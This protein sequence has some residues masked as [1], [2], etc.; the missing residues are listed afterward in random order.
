MTA[1][2]RKS[3]TRFGHWLVGAGV[4]A[5]LAFAWSG[6]VGFE[7]DGTLGPMQRHLYLATA[8]TLVIFFA[9]AWVVLYVS[10]LR[11]ELGGWATARGENLDLPTA[12]KLGWLAAA[13][14]LVL[15]TYLLGPAILMTDL[16][17]WAHAVV[18]VAALAAQAK[19][20]WVERQLLAASDRLL[21]SLAARSD[22]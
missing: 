10:N 16:P 6:L 3:I 11:R 20:L 13:C 8:A 2:A 14:G 9:H 17:T 19:A 22:A 5:T 7:L 4:A 18:A 15:A 1:K 21:L 12:S